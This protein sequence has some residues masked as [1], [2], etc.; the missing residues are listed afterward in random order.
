MTFTLSQERSQNDTVNYVCKKSA[1][2]N[3]AFHILCLKEQKYSLEWSMVTTIGSI[4]QI[5]EREQSTNTTRAIRTLASQEHPIPTP[6]ASWLP[7]LS[8][9][10]PFIKIRQSHLK[11][12]PPYIKRQILYWNRALVA[13]VALNIIYSPMSSGSYTRPVWYNIYVIWDDLLCVSVAIH[14]SQLLCSLI[15]LCGMRLIWI[16]GMGEWLLEQMRLIEQTKNCLYLG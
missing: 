10:I 14:C 5:S 6:T 1:T 7:I 4:T 11:Q 3:P 16:T 9:H 15:V 12:E 2:V 8:V 13:I